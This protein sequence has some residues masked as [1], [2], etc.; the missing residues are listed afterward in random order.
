MQR[1]HKTVTRY[2]T[3]KRRTKN[4]LEYTKG[5]SEQRF[6]KLST[7][8]IIPKI[9]QTLQCGLH[10]PG[11]T[12]PLRSQAALLFTPSSPYSE[13]LSLWAE[14]PHPPGPRIRVRLPARGAGG[15]WSLG[16]LTLTL[17]AASGALDASRAGFDLTCPSFF[18]PL[19]PKKATDHRSTVHLSRH[20]LLFWERALKRS[21]LLRS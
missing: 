15:L 4:F 19:N 20:L 7:G 11:R 10:C 8:E 17:H 12:R 9:D 3:G 21:S 18:R 16:S 1:I 2:Y 6:P 14:H 5:P 13:V